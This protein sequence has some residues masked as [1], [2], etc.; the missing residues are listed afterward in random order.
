M[1]GIEF[2][3]LGRNDKVK[4]NYLPAGRQAKAE[5]YSVA[6]I[7]A[8]QC[9]ALLLFRSFGVED[10]SYLQECS[11]VKFPMSLLAGYFESYRINARARL[12]IDPITRPRCIVPT[13]T[14]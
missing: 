12:T 3:P 10:L 2:Q 9:C 13:G 11:A 14:I 1:S 6:G 5:I 8:M 4:K 7:L